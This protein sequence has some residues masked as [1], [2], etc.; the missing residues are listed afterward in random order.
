M[1]SKERLSEIRRVLTSAYQESEWSDINDMAHEVFA[2]LD[3]L[4]EVLRDIAYNTSSSVPLGTWPV[5]H[6][7]W[8]MQR[9]VSLASNTLVENS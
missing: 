9:A 8:M 2:E 6:Y 5:D 7:R 4:T 3:R 1:A